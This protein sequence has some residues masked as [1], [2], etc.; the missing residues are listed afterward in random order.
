MTDNIG[1]W[2]KTIQDL[3][4]NLG[5]DY[6]PP[7]FPTGVAQ[8]FAPDWDWSV[9]YLNDKKVWEGHNCDTEPQRAIVEGMGGTYSMYE[10]TDEE[11]IDGC[12]PNKFSDIIGIKKLSAQ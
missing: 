10:F 7:S 6:T 11:E 8:V 4:E 12:T 3:C 9:V 2:N 1:G 5:P